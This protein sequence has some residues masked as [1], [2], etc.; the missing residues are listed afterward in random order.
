MTTPTP[1]NVSAWQYIADETD[2][3]ASCRATAKELL[4][5]Y[6][7]TVNIYDQHSKRVGELSALVADARRNIMPTLKVQIATS[8]KHSLVDL[9][10]DRRKAE[11][12]L[13]IANEEMKVADQ[14]LN[15]MRHK[16]S[17]ELKANRGTLLAWIATRR[18][19]NISAHGYT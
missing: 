1:E 7:I 12:M 18:V 14:L 11:E 19:L 9:V 16:L 4:R 5:Q 10:A 13:S 17:A 2:A 6:G 3:P 8:K 15:S